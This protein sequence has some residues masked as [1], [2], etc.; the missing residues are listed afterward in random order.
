MKIRAY[1][2]IRTPR[3]GACARV[4]AA[5]LLLVPVGSCVSYRGE[6]IVPASL[7]GLRSETVNVEGAQI[8]AQA[9]LDPLQAE[10][11]FGFNIRAAGLLPVRIAIDNRGRNVVNINPR[12]TFLIDRDSQAWPLLSSEQAY[13]RVAKAMDQGSVATIAKSSALWSAAGGIT[14]FALGVLLGKGIGTTTGHD[15]LI[16]AGLGAMAGDGETSNILENRIRKDLSSKTLRN[17]TIQPGDMAAGILFFPGK[18]EAKTAWA[19]RLSMDLDGYPREVNLPLG[20]LPQ[21]VPVQ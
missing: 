17:Q 12:Q 9:Y 11:A 19:I 3:L 4:M 10:A 21:V 8:A 16:G 14:G 1:F 18:D 13:N 5:A 20:Q 2:S 7:P 15:A 6:R